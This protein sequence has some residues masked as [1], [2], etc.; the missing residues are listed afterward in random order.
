MSN[1]NQRYSEN[2]KNASD[3]NTEYH[4]KI[5]ITAKKKIYNDKR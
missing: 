2:W 5:E 3:T 1:E 4:I